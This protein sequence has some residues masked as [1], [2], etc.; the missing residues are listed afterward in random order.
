MK[1]ITSLLF[2]ALAVTLAAS[3]DEPS[4]I[5]LGYVNGQQGSDYVKES[6]AGAETSAA[7]FL[8]PEM[9]TNFGGC[10]ISGV[11]ASMG[12]RMN[13][14][15]ITVWVRSSLNGANLCEATVAS[16]SK[17]WNEGSFATP[18]TLPDNISDGYYVG[19]TY[20]QTGATL[21]ISYLNE[22]TP[23]SAYF[24]SDGAEWTDQSDERAYAIEAIMSGDKLPLTNLKIETTEF[25]PFYALNRDEYKVSATIRNIGLRTVTGFDATV[26]M[27]DSPETFVRHFDCEIPTSS[28]YDFVI[29]VNPAIRDIAD[30]QRTVTLDITSIDEGEDIDRSDNIALGHY[31]IIPYDLT[32]HVLVE[33][34]TTERCS[35]CPR[36]A[37]WLHEVLEQPEY[38][39]MIVPLCH[40]AGY[41]TDQ[42]THEN[43][44][45]YLF[46]YKPNQYS[47]PSMMIDRLPRQD[48]PTFL[49]PSRE[50]IEALVSEEAGREANVSLV[51]EATKS[52]EAIEIS[53]K[54]AKVVEKLCDN[55]RIVCAITEDNIPTKKQAGWDGPG[56]YYQQH[57]TR[58]LNDPWGA[59][60]EFNADGTFDYT[61]R[62]ETKPAWIGDN[63]NVVVY[64]FNYDPDNRNNCMV[65]NAAIVHA[66]AFGQASVETI[67]ADTVDAE[68]WYSISGHRFTRRPS[69][70][71][72]YI[73]KHNSGTEKTI[74]R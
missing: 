10:D 53:V 21:G 23:G 40:H 39:E 55:P 32:R 26:T 37:G 38:A 48:T 8:S 41:G 4:T 15:E 52:P 66:S 9:L 20:T 57:V 1:R 25:Q 69:T 28:T 13:I 45:D 61:C 58:A 42:F 3:A 74:I 65:E 56:D 46:F 33:E 43:D 31:E 71:G 47:A 19:V 7:I 5:A 64:I 24:K 6:Q 14:S 63:L 27:E 36:V 67:A 51:V 29:V 72:I 11:R 34:F 73:H 30:G 68:S 35:N 50:T 70:P 44:E 12:A 62:L 17:G 2:T 60:V 16:P 22:A 18:L 54:S 49:P 59:P